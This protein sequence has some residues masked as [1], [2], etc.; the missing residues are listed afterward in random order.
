M[1]CQDQG[2]TQVNT[3]DSHQDRLVRAK[4][5]STVI[6][7]VSESEQADIARLAALN[8]RSLSREVRRAIRFY[9]VFADTADRAL[10]DTAGPDRFTPDEQVETG[11]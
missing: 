3:S 11:G 2:M 6:S 7:R 8:D 10:R 1:I 9:L 5:G 4:L